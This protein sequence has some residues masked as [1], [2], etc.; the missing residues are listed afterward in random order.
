MTTKYLVAALLALTAVL[1]LS[2]CVV[3]HDDG[4]RYDD[5]GYRYDHGDRVSREGRRD[6]GW[7]SVHRDDVHCR[8]ATGP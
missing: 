8:V 3:A 2:G 6:V 5:E 7:C 1:N 4:Y